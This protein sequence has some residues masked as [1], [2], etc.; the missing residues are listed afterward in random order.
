MAQAD[1]DV[2]WVGHRDGM[3]FRTTN[4]TAAV[5]TWA[6]MGAA[7]PTALK[8]QRYRTAITVHPTDPDTVYVA[9][10]GYLTDDLWVTRNRGA[11]WAPPATAL[12]PAPV[13]AVAVHPRRSDHVYLS[14]DVG[15]LASEDA[16]VRWSPTN[17]GPANCSVDDLIWMGDT[18][19]AITHGRGMVWID[20]SGV[21]M[22]GECHLRRPAGG[23]PR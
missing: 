6:R 14:T 8:P 7:G 3:V 16:G 15:V 1:S 12:P 13:R 23:C 5:P 22:P 20:L 2:A 10:G 18:L 19:I 9:F 21:R 11:D 17:E 4:G